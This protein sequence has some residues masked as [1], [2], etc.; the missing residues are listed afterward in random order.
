MTS[1]FG[2]GPDQ[3][4]LFAI[5]FT[6]AVDDCNAH[7]VGR[8]CDKPAPL[9]DVLAVMKGHRDAP[10]RLKSGHKWSFNSW[11]SFIKIQEWVEV[12]GDFEIIQ[13]GRVTRI[14]RRDPFRAAVIKAVNQA[15]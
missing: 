15:E 12:Q 9:K 3:M 11:N 2:L 10:G 14:R 4:K 5:D 1:L 6:D 13:D 8:F 7:R